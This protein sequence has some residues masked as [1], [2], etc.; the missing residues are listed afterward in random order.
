METNFTAAQLAD[1]ALYG[2]ADKDALQAL[3]KRQAELAQAIAQAEEAWL[4]LHERL[5]AL[6]PIN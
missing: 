2:S 1:P 6:P 5:E 3:L 4:M